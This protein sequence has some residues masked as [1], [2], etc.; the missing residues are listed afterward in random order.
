MLA[1]KTSVSPN[2]VLS[3]ITFRLSGCQQLLQPNQE[4]LA[5]PLQ[6]GCYAAP[7]VYKSSSLRPVRFAIRASIFGPISSPS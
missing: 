3:G 6:P 7:M 1:N 4:F 2:Q 5:N